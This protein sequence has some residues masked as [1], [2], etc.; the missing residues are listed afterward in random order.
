M[1]TFTGYLYG[2]MFLA[3]FNKEIDWDTDT[4]QVILTTSAHTPDQDNHDYLNDLTNEVSGGG[5]SR[6]TLA[7]KTITYTGATNVF[8]VDAADVTFSSATFTFR[9]VHV[10][11]TSPAT[12]ATRPLICYQQGDA[13][14]TG[15]GGDLVLQ[16]H[17]SGIFTVT[18]S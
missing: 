7:S 17:S 2:R 6:Q 4:I 1:A 11:D 15:A 9:N 16:W 5:Y 18:V 3:A 8:A 10:V 12:D 13:D 14:V